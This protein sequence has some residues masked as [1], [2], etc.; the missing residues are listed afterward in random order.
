MCKR[1]VLSSALAGLVL[2]LL[3]GRV[4][5]DDAADA[6]QASAQ[7]AVSILQQH[8]WKC[9]GSNKQK[10]SLRLD[11]RSEALAGG[12]SG[13]AIHAGKSG[14]SPLFERITSEDAD[15]RM[16]P[17][18]PRLSAEQISVLRSWIDAGAP[19][20]E[21]DE[22]A[23]PTHDKR[24]DEWTWQPVRRPAVPAVQDV[25][26]ADGRPTKWARTPID[27]FILAKLQAAG[28]SP[29]P[30]AD[31]RTLIRRLTFDLH[32]LPPTPE[33]VAAFVADA[34][35]QAYEK[36]VDRLLASPRYGERW[37]RHWLDIAHYAD[38][39]GFERDQRRDHAW[40]YRDWVIDAFNNDDP[41]DEFLRDQIAGDLLDFIRS[42][43][44]PD[45]IAATG[46]GPR[47]FPLHHAFARMAGAIEQRQQCFR[48]A[49]QFG[50]AP[51][52]ALIGSQ[53]D[54]R[55]RRGVQVIDAQV[56]VEHE[57]AGDQCVEQLVAVEAQRTQGEFSSHGACPGCGIEIGSGSLVRARTQR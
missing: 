14:E 37:A 1:S 25:A 15:V 11:S 33:E 10:G 53:A 20:P 5:A 29:Q 24:R 19:W 52:Q 50:D 48:T 44:R 36:L 6:S 42:D 26:A 43:L 23:E 34:D 8:C 35:P 27:A 31:R 51:A 40:P 18:G 49:R 32:G 47:Q 3:A 17:E 45:A 9:H 2:I 16:P 38:T 30:E 28:L 41:Y 4:F 12:E 54:E 46:R 13:V 56:G 22:Q 21:A 39:H 55:L 57:H 7:Q